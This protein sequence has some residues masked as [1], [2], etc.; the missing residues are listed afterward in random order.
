MGQPYNQVPLQPRID[1]LVRQGWRVVSQ[2]SEGAQLVRPKTF[3]FLWAT[4]WF[5]LCGVGVLVYVF[6]Y[7]S[8]KDEQVYL[9]APITPS[10]AG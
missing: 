8:K 9:R 5:L 4:A 1:M 10:P 6:Y 3:S 2:S 7:A